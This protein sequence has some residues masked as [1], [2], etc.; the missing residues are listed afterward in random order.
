MAGHA[1]LAATRNHVL[2]AWGPASGGGV[3]LRARCARGWEAVAGTQH[4][5]LQCP[6][7][8]CLA[9]L[10]PTHPGRVG[11][12]GT[13]DIVGRCPALR[14]LLLEWLLE[15]GGA[16]PKPCAIAY[17]PESWD[18]RGG[19]QRRGRQTYDSVVTA[20]DVGPTGTLVGRTVGGQRG[21]RE[22]GGRGGLVQ[23][24]GR[25]AFSTWRLD[26]WVPEPE[27]PS[28]HHSIWKRDRRR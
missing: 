14:D 1:R 20:L 26:C 15:F 16:E 13:E 10:R 28:G 7:A 22:A 9:A 23:A 18:L 24:A 17:F 8:S 12:L 3:W 19:R 2:P 27:E 4:G 6:R 25:A 11:V 21:G 5:S